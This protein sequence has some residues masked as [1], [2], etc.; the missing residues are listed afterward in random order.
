[1]EQRVGFL[2]GY[3]SEDPNYPDGVRVNIEAIYEPKQIG[4]YSGFHIIDEDDDFQVDIL[5]QSLSLQRVGWIFTSVDPQN[6]VNPDDIRKIAE[7]QERYQVRHPE[8]FNVSKFVTLVLKPA[9]DGGDTLMEAYM[10]SDQCQ[11]LNRDKI[12]GDSKG[13]KL[14]V[15]EP[16]DE[17]DLV[18][19]VLMESK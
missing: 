17:A 6:Y 1:M 9:S 2:Y 10:V 4:D 14:L 7:M 19:I 13:K 3:Y 8:G 15:R 18:P 5:A 16:T 12:F 11:A